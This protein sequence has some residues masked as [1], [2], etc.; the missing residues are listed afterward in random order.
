MLHWFQ[1]L[2]QWLESE[3][4]A[5][6]YTLAELHDKMTEFSGGLDVYT[7]K[8]LKQ[9][10]HEYYKDFIFFAE[11]EGRGNVLCFR[12]MAS[13]IINDKWHLKRKE[14]TEEEAEHIV[15][16]AAKI[17]R[18]EIREN[19]YDVKSYPTNEDIAN[20]NQGKKWIPHYL[21]TFLGIMNSSR[22]ALAIPLFNLLG[23]GQL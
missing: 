5:E 21:Q 13:Y 12:N 2:C 17:I 15:R 8:R 16:A 6:L 7:P 19:I 20:V 3:A 10:L 11:V 18:A 9:K 14:N 4:D 1:M 23:Q 22:T